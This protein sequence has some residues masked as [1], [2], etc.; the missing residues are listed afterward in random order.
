MAGRPPTCGGE[1]L[2]GGELVAA[3]GDGGGAIEQRHA[4]R[5]E[6]AD[7]GQPRR[8]DARADARQHDRE[9]AQLLAAVEDARLARLENEIALEHVDDAGAKAAGARRLEQPAARVQALLAREQRERRPQLYA[10]HH[11]GHAP[12]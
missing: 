5:L 3:A 6:L 12:Q 7:H 9:P 1:L 8:G 10:P 2:Q 4:L 11:P